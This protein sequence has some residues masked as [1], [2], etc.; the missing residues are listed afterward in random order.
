MI[1]QR[2]EV[3]VADFGLA[4][5]NQGENKNDLTQV[6]MTMG[7]P[8]YM[9]PEQVQ[10][11]HVDVRSDL[12]SLGVTIY[13]LLVGRPPF[14]A[15]TPLA[16]AIKHLHEKP[17]PIAE[18]RPAGD[19]PKWLSEA[20]E[21]LME[22]SPGNR[23][24]TPQA[25]NDFIRRSM[26]RNGSVGT[27]TTTLATRIDATRTLQQLMVSEQRPVA[28]RQSAKW[29]A[30]LLLPAT[31][32]GIG[33]TSA[34]QKP[35]TELAELLEPGK[36]EVVTRDN[37]TSQYLEAARLNEPEAWLKVIKAFPPRDN[38]VNA[39]Y[40]A[41]AKIQLGRL[42]RNRKEFQN[43]IGILVEV[44]QDQ[45]VAKLDKTIAKAEILLT[46]QT[47]EDSAGAA[48]TKAELQALYLEVC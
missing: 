22:K 23:F 29:L 8:L 47:S 20:V 2:G 24:Q 33:Y 28:W 6:G 43:S 5:V 1:S 34:N 16:I 26:S 3:K 42:Y 32:F 27:E 13:H 40:A 38:P 48:A 10:G 12:Y 19:V 31:A 36:L 7:T 44:V 46:Q 25:L 39:S 9:S 17:T 4:R 14:E 15:D 45:T 30:M 35:P 41:K 21:R 18:A 37:V 11:Q